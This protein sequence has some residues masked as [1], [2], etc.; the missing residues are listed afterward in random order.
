MREVTLN[1]PAQTVGDPARL[2]R[3]TRHLKARLLD[4]G[5]G[6][7]QVLRA[8]E[9]L[10]RV[11]VFFPGHKTEEVLDALAQS[12]GVHAAAE[13][14]QAVFFLTGDTRFEDLDYVWGCLF[15]I[16]S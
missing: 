14:D 16:L 7:P 2:A 6:G 9:K 5:P 8:D 1:R 13:K 3:L 4:F 10:G 15:E 11:T 12:C